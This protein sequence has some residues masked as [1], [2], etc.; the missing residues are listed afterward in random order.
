VHSPNWSK[1]HCTCVYTY[2]NDFS[3]TD[4]VDPSQ[5]N[6]HVWSV[7]TTAC[8]SSVTSHGCLVS[9]HHDQW[10]HQV[11]VNNTVNSIFVNCQFKLSWYNNCQNR[12][13]KIC[14]AYT[15]EPLYQRA[16]CP[17]VPRHFQFSFLS[18]ILDL[19]TEQRKAAGTTPMYVIKLQGG[20]NQAYVDLTSATCPH[21]T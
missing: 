6:S 13:S 11:T 18:S 8:Y 3:N 2:R 4:N 15:L 19:W 16:Q 1:C 12:I 7:N 9:V 17:L 5:P 14:F 10:P 21:T 20:P